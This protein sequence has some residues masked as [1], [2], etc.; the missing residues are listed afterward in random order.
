MDDYS[1][2]K[3]LLDGVDRVLFSSEQIQTRVEELGSRISRDYVAK[4]WSSPLLAVMSSLWKI[5]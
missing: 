1:L 3:E 2:N 4:T 5:L